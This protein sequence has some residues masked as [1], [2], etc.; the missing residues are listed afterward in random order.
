MTAATRL[1]TKFRFL[2]PVVKESVQRFA[3]QVEPTLNRTTLGELAIVT[4]E[5]F[6][7]DVF[8]TG[9]KLAEEYLKNNFSKEIQYRYRGNQSQIRNQATILGLIS[10]ILNQLKEIKKGRRG[11]VMVKKDISK[12]L[13]SSSSSHLLSQAWFLFIDNNF[14]QI[15][16]ATQQKQQDLSVAEIEEMLDLLET[17]N[18]LLEETLIAPIGNVFEAH[19]YDMYRLWKQKFAPGSVNNNA[20]R[21][22]EFM[23][24]VN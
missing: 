1:L 7:R 22:R 9:K 17:D 14:Q 8:K 19:S 12:Y 24:E 15:L 21:Y 18:Q 4:K 3:Q 10:L 2:I 23:A 11:P 5:Q 20:R 13:N 16:N 6:G